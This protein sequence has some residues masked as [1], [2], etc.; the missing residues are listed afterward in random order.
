MAIL[1]GTDHNISVAAFP[2]LQCNIAL[3]TFDFG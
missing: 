2:S 1:N 3:M